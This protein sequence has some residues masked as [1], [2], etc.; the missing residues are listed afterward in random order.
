MWITWNGAKG[1]GDLGRPLGQARKS[2]TQRPRDWRG[3]RRDLLL[4]E[5]QVPLVSSLSSSLP[6]SFSWLWLPLFL[7]ERHPFLL[8]LVSTSKKSRSSFLTKNKLK[9]TSSDTSDSQ[10]ALWKHQET[11]WNSLWWAWKKN[12]CKLVHFWQIIPNAQ[13]VH[14]PI[15]QFF[16]W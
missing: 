10:F 1:G 11:C 2:H 13:C 12:K 8:F 16:F 6:A 4:V 9:N 5:D 14:R 3:H 15:Q 7:T